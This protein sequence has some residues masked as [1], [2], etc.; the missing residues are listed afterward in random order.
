MTTFCCWCFRRFFFGRLDF[1]YIA[2]NIFQYFDFDFFQHFG[3][4]NIL[5][6]SSCSAWQS[7]APYIFSFFRI[8]VLFWGGCCLVSRN[9]NYKNCLKTAAVYSSTSSLSKWW[10]RRSTSTAA[11]TAAPPTPQKSSVRPRRRWSL[12]V[13]VVLGGG[14]VLVVVVNMKREEEK[15]GAA[16]SI[17]SIERGASSIA[18][19][20][21]HSVA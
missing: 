14:G 1:L 8:W 7:E 16:E 19:T 10:P 2:S 9:K 21:Y 15:E 11:T 13:I 20:I 5:R 6:C 3:C 4:D 12:L 18:S 17:V